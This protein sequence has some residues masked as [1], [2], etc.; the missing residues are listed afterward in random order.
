[1]ALLEDDLRA[2]KDDILIR[3]GYILV[4]RRAFILP[5]VAV[6]AGQPPWLEH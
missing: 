5:T 6:F 1:M 4:K 3:L 2:R